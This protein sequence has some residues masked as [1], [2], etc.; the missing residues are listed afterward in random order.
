MKNKNIRYWFF[1]A[2]VTTARIAFHVKRYY[3]NRYNRENVPPARSHPVA[4]G[5]DVIRRFVS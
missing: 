5:L 3:F 4:S 2:P 1:C